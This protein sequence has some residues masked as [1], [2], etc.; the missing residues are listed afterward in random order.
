MRSSSH[1]YLSRLDHLR[2]LAALL[3]LVWHA[4]HLS[5]P[6][7]Y[8]PPLA[9]FPLSLFEEGHTGVALFMVLSGYS[10]MALCRDREIVYADFLRNR[11]LRIAPLFLFWLSLTLWTTPTADAVKVLASVAT[12]T[13]P[14]DQMP[15]VGWTVLVEFQFYLLFPFLLLFYRREGLRFL[16]GLL[17]V[18]LA[19]RL[20]VYL[21]SGDVKTLA[22]RSLFGRV[23]QLLL[24]MVACEVARLRP[25]LCR[26]PW[27][28][29]GSVVGWL[30]AYHWFNKLGGYSD[31]GGSWIWVV[32]PTSEGV[33]YATWTA[34]YLA[35][36]VVLPRWIDD[37][38]AWMDKLSF[39]FYVNHV[40]LIH[41][42]LALCA[43]TG[44]RPDSFKTALAFTFLVVL[45]LVTLFSALT[46]HFIELPF[47]SL[48]RSYLAALK[49]EDAAPRLAA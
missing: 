17:A 20:A 32:L 28:F 16:A 31:F 49:P 33:A 30:L 47:L 10:F 19:T 23:D 3:V 1:L 2:F 40:L 12:L 48:R 9:L 14:Q 35:C 4:V 7:R 41:A 8:A 25:A 42:G 38:L 46:Y 29:G 34:C 22:Y 5:V 45:P 18:A 26:S 43:A 27:V 37:G 13:S 6:T 39:S 24:G 36:P 44:L 15:G 21:G 11:V